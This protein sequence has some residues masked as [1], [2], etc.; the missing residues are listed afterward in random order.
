MLFADVH[1]FSKLNDV[2]LPPFAAHIMG[3]LAQAA[4]AYRGEIAFLN[5]WGDGIFAVLA[6]VGIAAALALKLQEGHA[7]HRPGPDGAAGSICGYGWAG[8]WGRRMS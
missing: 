8:T 5:T 2:Q 3:P 1:G 7:R 6:D 4:D